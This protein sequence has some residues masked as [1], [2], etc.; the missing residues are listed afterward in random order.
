MTTSDH[1]HTAFP[2]DSAFLDADPLHLSEH[3]DL[4]DFDFMLEDAAGLDEEHVF[5]NSRGSSDLDM[6]LANGMVGIAGNSRDG[7]RRSSFDI[8]AGLASSKG[9][10]GMDFQLET[11]LKSSMTRLTFDAV[12]ENGDDKATTVMRSSSGSSGYRPSRRR[13][14]TRRSA[15][16]PSL[17]GSAPA[18]SFQMGAMNF[19]PA[20]QSS[21]PQAQQPT[22]SFKTHQRQTSHGDL[23]MCSYTT[24]QSSVAQSINRRMS[25][26]A[27]STSS[28]SSSE[29]PSQYNKAL[30][31]L[32]ES[33]KRTEESRSQVMKQ[34][35]V[36]LSP[37][38]ESAL[39]RAKEQLQKQNEQMSRQQAA[40]VT[41]PQDTQRSSI[42]SAFLSG[43]RGTLTTGLEQSRRQMGMYMGQ[44]N[45]HTL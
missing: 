30:Q 38:Q 29:G 22:R 39:V 7:S 5:A 3:G 34:R 36:M 20:P 15:Q 24:A 6:L 40:P 44:V 2:D 27:S 35:K 19:D 21:A 32:A 14:S 10:M 37:E 1:I 18:R 31:R 28:S 26:H 4:D 17:H 45:N 23:S 42:V 13:A 25:E 8:L 11:E 16:D 9:S 33:M 12:E 41:P 43:S